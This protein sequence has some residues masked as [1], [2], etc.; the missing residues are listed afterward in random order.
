MSCR[1]SRIGCCLFGTLVQ[2]ASLFPCHQQ[3]DIAMT[4]NQD[5]LGQRSKQD[6][7]VFA[8]EWRMMANLAAGADAE[9]SEIEVV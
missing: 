2:V 4:L 8:I 7:E 1:Y 3:G 9:I 5:A 6:W